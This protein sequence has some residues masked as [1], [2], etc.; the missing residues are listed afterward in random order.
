M[1]DS[2]PLRLLHPLPT[3]PASR[4]GRITDLSRLGGLGRSGVGG[5][6]SEMGGARRPDNMYEFRIL[7]L[8]QLNPA[9]P[10][11]K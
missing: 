2:G 6:F 8:Y 7:M 10:V 1:A 3:L 4:L 9:L 5:Y 11:Y